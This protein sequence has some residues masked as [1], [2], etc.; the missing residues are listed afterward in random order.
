MRCC[1]NHLSYTP[2]NKNF[3]SLG[4]Q[5]HFTRK[6]LTKHSKLFQSLAHLGA[7]YHHQLYYNCVRMSLSQET[8]RERSPRSRKSIESWNPAWSGSTGPPEICAALLL[9]RSP[10]YIL[11]IYMYVLVG[12]WLAGVSLEKFHATVSLALF[13]R[14]TSI[15]NK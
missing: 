2:K 13:T 15:I 1:E 6:T 11:Y 10:F 7:N 3:S 9:R 8:E 4:Q 14:S 5:H 12:G